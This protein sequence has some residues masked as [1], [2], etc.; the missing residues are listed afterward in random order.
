MP[1]PVDRADVG[2][3]IGVRQCEHE[4]ITL[5]SAGSDFGIDVHFSLLC[6]QPDGT[7]IEWKADNTPASGDHPLG[8]IAIRSAV[9][10]AELSGSMSVRL[11][12]LQCSPVGKLQNLHQYFCHAAWAHAKTEAGACCSRCEKVE[13]RQKLRWPYPNQ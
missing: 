9:T 1:W 2:A 12:N 10:N 11:C 13:P 8:M 5:C 6:P 3:V 4:C 7:E